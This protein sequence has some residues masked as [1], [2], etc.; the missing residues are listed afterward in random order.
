MRQKKRYRLQSNIIYANLKARN[1]GTYR[2][3]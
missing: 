2:D 3:L 1:E